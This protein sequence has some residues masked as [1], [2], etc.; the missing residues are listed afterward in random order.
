MK[1]AGY[2]ETPFEHRVEAALARIPELQNCPLAYALAASPV[3]SPT[4]RAVASDCLRVALDGE[5]EIFLKIRHADMADDL[6]PA[7]MRAAERAGRLGIGPAVRFAGEGHIGLDF[8]P[9]PWRYARVGDLQASGTLAAVLAALRRLQAEALF[10]HRFCPFARIEALAREADAV[11]APLPDG[12]GDLIAAAALIGEAMRASGIDL[13]P[14]RNDGIASNVMLGLEGGRESIRL[15]DFDLAGDADPWFEVG[16]LINEACRFEDERRAAVE[17]YAGACDPRRLDRCR[18]YG[19]VDD[20][21]WGLWG[22]VRAVTAPR[23]GIEFFKY[24]QWRLFHAR[25]TTGARD[26]EAWLRNL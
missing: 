17:A 6:T 7:A 12:T 10:G 25:T 4:H 15:V 19:A 16:A 24:G 5:A 8:L 14:C 13:R 3:A 11:G 23:G 9:D 1:L 2:P 26:F 20:V 18:L 21:M 22:I